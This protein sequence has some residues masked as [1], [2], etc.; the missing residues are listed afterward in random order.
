MLGS[1]PVTLRNLFRT[2][3]QLALSVFNKLSKIRLDKLKPASLKEAEYRAVTITPSHTD[4]F[5]GE[6]MDQ[7]AESQKEAKAYKALAEPPKKK[8]RPQ[9]GPKG[10]FFI[11]C[12]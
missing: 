2:N 11:K 4:I 6:F 5:G 8:D 10:T 1:D 12:F 9:Q 7:L 3:T